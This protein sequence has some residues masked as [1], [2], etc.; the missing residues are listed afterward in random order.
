[1]E[2]ASVTK[3]MEELVFEKLISGYERQ[4][5]DLRGSLGSAHDTIT[6]LRAKC[7]HEMS[8]SSGLRRREMLAELPIRELYEAAYNSAKVGAKGYARL[9]AA[10]AAAKE[11][12]SFIP[13]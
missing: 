12:V 4:I 3:S 9:R 7:D 6:S 2:E 13:F 10:L 8:V 1:M 11:H 5:A